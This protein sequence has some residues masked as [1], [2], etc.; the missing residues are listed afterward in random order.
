MQEVVPTGA[1]LLAPPQIDQMAMA[2]R[3]AVVVSCRNGPHDGQSWQEFMER[4]NAIGGIDQC[5]F[6]GRGSSYGNL[7]PADLA[8][9]A[10]RFGASYVVVEQDQLWRR[11]A[12]VDAGWKVVVEPLGTADFAVFA[13]P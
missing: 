6:A 8:A 1:V 2:T 4:M 10:G 3:R 13:V 7:S 11:E 5:T 9:A 12:L